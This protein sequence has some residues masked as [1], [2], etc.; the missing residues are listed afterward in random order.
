MTE[1]DGHSTKI[2][3]FLRFFDSGEN[4]RCNQKNSCAYFYY[5]QKINYPAA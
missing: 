1:A 2:I 4:K 3:E 5:Q